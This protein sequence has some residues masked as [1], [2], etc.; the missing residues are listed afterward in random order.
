M[1]REYKFT[2]LFLFL[3]GLVFSQVT[4]TVQDL[5]GEP[6]PYVNIYTEDGRTGTTTNEDGNYALKLQ[7][8]GIYT[9]VFQYLGF[10]THR[11][12]VTIEK[13]P[14]S[15]NIQLTPAT[16]TLDEVI[17]NSNENPANKIIRNAI[18]S[19]KTNL[20]KLEQYTAD[21][22]SRGIWRIRNAPERILGQDIGDL[23][24]GL[25]STRSGIVYLSETISE[26]TY[27]AP[28]DFKEKIIASKV[29]GNDN[30]F[31]L[32]SARESEFSFY[33]NTI[34]I[35]ASIVS[36][37]AD[38]AFNYYNYR[39]E[40]VFY[41]ENG[42]LINKI[43][44]TPKRPKDR[45]F[46]GSIYIVED[47]WQIYGVELDVTGEAIQFEAIETLTFTQN[48][49]YSEAYKFWVKISQTVDFSFAMFGISGDGRFTAV[50]S[51]YNFSPQF[52]RNTFS[53]E[54]MSFAEAANKK[55]SVFWQTVR[56]VPLTNEELT[57][58]IKKDSIQVLR[59][60]KT[61]L[62]SVDSVRNKFNL[63]NVAFGYSYSNS[64]EKNNFNITSPLLGTQF[65][66][67]QGWNTTLN[68]GF[69][70]NYDEN[71]SRYWRIGGT[72]NYGF[73]DD[74]LRYTALFQKKFNNISKPIL[75]VSGGVQASQINNTIP[76]S[77]RINT[78]TS[79]LYQRNYMKLYER[80]FAEVAYQ[81]ELFNGLR[82]FSDLSY[83]QRNVLY[84]T[85][86]QAWRNRDGVDYTS[87]NPLQPLVEGTAPF[88]NHSIYKFN[89]NA[90]IDFAQNYMSYPDG[91]FN[92]GN[93][94]YPTL[95]LGYEKGFGASISNYDFD[96][97]KISLSQ[98]LN[99]GNKGAFTYNLRS[100]TFLNGGDIAFPDYQHFN[101]NQ[102]RVGDGFYSDRF[103]MLPYYDFSTNK[104]YLEGHVEHDFKG[105][106]LGKIPGINQLNF[107][108]VLGAHFLSTENNKP[109]TEVSAGIDNLGF[110]KYRFLRLDYL[111][112]S[113]DGNRNGAFIF[114]LK[115]L[116]ILD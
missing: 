6:L 58:Y 73:S 69:R 13:F 53:R 7:A 66:T 56:P 81:Q 17:V 86:N 98:N 26:I 29:S 44:V 22:Y 57:D 75:T 92:I 38:Y 39:L 111:V 106:V 83:N 49:K 79:L 2:L 20:A 54:V 33:G 87:N 50:Y 43:Q 105:W 46:Q 72:L 42:Q 108:L 61:Y 48:F 103:L 74:R 45:V 19:R 109:Y 31:S 70:Q 95:I 94:K 116:R 12:A 37:I 34:D 76:I 4:G 64:Y 47:S 89:L 91:K 55:D 52:D 1:T 85:T 82:F 41:D 18:N 104:T 62:D 16:T 110:G 36:P 24:G 9:L 93:N 63:S 65:N 11:E 32:N 90:R 25:D 3:T 14:F 101:G 67:V 60:S 97:F 78:V 68:I 84:N 28:D 15:L 112:S 59:S 5:Q 21:Y 115:F 35:N 27:R 51:N 30:G 107:N 99:T 10:E 40:G 100:G 113:F 8:P 102:T 114:G 88:N 96:Q 80:Q 77:E 71:Y 23:G